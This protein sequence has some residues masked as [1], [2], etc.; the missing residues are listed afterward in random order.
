MLSYREHNGAALGAPLLW[1]PWH[2]DPAL[3]LLL[4]LQVVAVAAL[5]GSL[6]HHKHTEGVNNQLSLSPPPSCPDLLIRSVTEHKDVGTWAHGYVC[7][8]PTEST[9]NC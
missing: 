8:L 7:Q 3:L 6:V 5:L 9:G 2:G 1:G 4:R